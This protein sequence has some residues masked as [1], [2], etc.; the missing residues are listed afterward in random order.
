MNMLERRNVYD[1]KNIVIASRWGC[2]SIQNNVLFAWQRQIWNSVRNVSFTCVGGTKVFTL[3][4]KEIVIHLK[5]SSED[6]KE[7]FLL[8]PG[9]FGV[10]N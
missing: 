1:W 6:A 8:P 3:Q 4:K 7:E 5:L 2:Q 9:T 10:E